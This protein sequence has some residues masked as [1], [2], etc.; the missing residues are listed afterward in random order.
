MCLVTRRGRWNLVFF[1]L[2]YE[3]DLDQ[4]NLR[5]ADE[6]TWGDTE[7][8]RYLAMNN[9]R[10][11]VAG[12]YEKG[13]SNNLYQNRVKYSKSLLV[14]DFREVEY[15]S[16]SGGIIDIGQNGER[17]IGLY[18]Y[19][20]TVVVFK[21]SGLF[22]IRGTDE[23]FTVDAVPGNITPIDSDNIA[24]EK[25]RPIVLPYAGRTCLL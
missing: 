25:K 23:P 22:V 8:G 1:G 18:A 17:I 13:N 16:T 4:I 10:S 20:D 19:L 6:E 14:F 24:I 5:Y 15:P 9:E 12:I 11:F 3:K 7:G 2:I 21:P